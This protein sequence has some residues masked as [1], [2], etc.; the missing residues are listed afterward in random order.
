MYIVSFTASSICILICDIII[1][2]TGST[3]ALV[4]PIYSINYARMLV[5]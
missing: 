5:S 3:E 2:N 4:L 1:L